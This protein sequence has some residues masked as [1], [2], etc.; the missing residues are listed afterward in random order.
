MS[1]KF[2]F[3]GFFDQAEA[4]QKY[5]NNF[6]TNSLPKADLMNRLNIVKFLLCLSETPTVKFL[7]NPEE[8][9]VN[10]TDDEEDQIDWKLYLNE[11]IEGWTPNFDSITSDEVSLNNCTGLIE[12]HN[13]KKYIS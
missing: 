11:G 13:V 5:Y 4:L 2:T 6:I 9:V 3:H 10:S 8:F 7:A 1:E 12:F